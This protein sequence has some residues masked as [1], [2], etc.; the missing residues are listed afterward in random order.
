LYGVNRFGTKINAIQVST[1]AKRTRG[2]YRNRETHTS[3]CQTENDSSEVNADLSN[4]GT[5]ELSV[6]ENAIAKTAAFFGGNPSGH[7]S[8]NEVVAVVKEPQNL[9]SLKQGII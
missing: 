6:Q 8:V 4:D 7:A 5:N 3:Q 9:D 2:G 1:N